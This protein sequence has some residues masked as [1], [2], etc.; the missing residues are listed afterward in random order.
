MLVEK[1]E[2]LGGIIKSSVNHRGSARAAACQCRSVA[3]TDP[4]LHGPVA[5]LL[6][7]LPTSEASS[8]PPEFVKP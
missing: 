8:Y 4:A 5:V 2:I 7:A 3:H 1:E 6:P